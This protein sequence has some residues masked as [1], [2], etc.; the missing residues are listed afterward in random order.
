MNPIVENKIRW[1][2]SHDTPAALFG[3]HMVTLLEQGLAT[4]KEVCDADRYYRS[5]AKRKGR[6]LLQMLEEAEKEEA[7]EDE[8]E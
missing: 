5:I 1:C 3:S 4:S 7:E 8:E 2:V 6:D